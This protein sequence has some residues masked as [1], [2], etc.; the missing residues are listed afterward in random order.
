MTASSPNTLEEGQAAPPSNR[1][2][3]MFVVLVG[4]AAVVFAPCVLLPIWRD[5]QALR[6]AEQVEQAELERAR[7]LLQLQRRRLEALQN[8][9]AAIARVARRELGYRDPHEFTV[10]V[11]L[12]PEQV[13]EIAPVALTPVE[14]PGVVAGLVGKLPAA[15]YDSIFC[16]EPTR[17][18]LMCLAG[19]LL[20]SAMVI[21]APRQSH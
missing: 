15:D 3:G 11:V 18:I 6:Y 5:Y 21:Y 17:T 8:D 4:M 20:L 2:N 9:P 10:P 7:A 12:A 19:G 16:H 13:V 1:G 14:P